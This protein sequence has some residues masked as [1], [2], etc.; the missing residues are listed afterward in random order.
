[1]RLAQ[2]FGQPM[3]A[4]AATA[5]VGAPL[6]A[7]VNLLTLDAPSVVAQ[8]TS[9][10]SPP[11][12]MSFAQSLRAEMRP[13]GIRVLNVY[14]SAPPA[15]QLAPAALARAVVKALQE[16][17]EDLYLGELPQDWVARWCSTGS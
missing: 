12:A 6:S 3:R 2:A 7:W 4:T 1:V 5:L 11:A 15:P 10:A 13:A 8:V 9:I 14:D 16:G 17:I